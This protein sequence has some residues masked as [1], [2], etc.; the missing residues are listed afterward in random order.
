[1]REMKTVPVTEHRRVGHLATVTEARREMQTVG[2]SGSMMAWN[3]VHDSDEVRVAP[4]DE[5]T[6]PQTGP[7][8]EPQNREYSILE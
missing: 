3:L 6:E 2:M 4:T 5:M 7:W 1:M 8:M